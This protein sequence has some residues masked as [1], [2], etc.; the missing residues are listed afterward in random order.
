[1]TAAQPGI[2]WEF[3]SFDNFL[4]WATDLIHLPS[5]AQLSDIRTLFIALAADMERLGQPVQDPEDNVE[6]QQRIQALEST[7]VK[8]P[9]SVSISFYSL[10]SRPN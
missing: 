7:W 9:S 1:M 6:E 10:R 2:D 3:G 8:F 5:S 4:D